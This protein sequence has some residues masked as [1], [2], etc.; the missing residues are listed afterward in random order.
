MQAGSGRRCAHKSNL[1]APQR[2]VQWV[3]AIERQG[4]GRV[5]VAVSLGHRHPPPHRHFSSTLP[6]RRSGH[7]KA[8]QPVGAATL[9]HMN[10]IAIALAHPCHVNACVIVHCHRFKLLGASPPHL[11]GG[12]GSGGGATAILR[13]QHYT[14]GGIIAVWLAAPHLQPPPTGSTLTTCPAVAGRGPIRVGAE[15]IPLG[16]RRDGRG[17]RHPGARAP[18]A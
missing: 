15:G 16:A 14:C 11:Y 10:A 2:E 1:H 12:P 17:A 13:H 8:P 7:C 4:T 5:R 9:P 18:I 6:P 3:R